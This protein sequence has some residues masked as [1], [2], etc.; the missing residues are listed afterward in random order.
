MTCSS[1]DPLQWMG[2]VR[3]G[4]QTAKKTFGVIHKFISSS[5]AIV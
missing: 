2:A 1:M 4:V 3:M 5:I